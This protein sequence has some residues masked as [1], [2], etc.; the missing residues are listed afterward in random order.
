[1]PPSSAQPPA[2]ASMADGPW[3]CSFTVQRQRRHDTVHTAAG[4]SLIEQAKFAQLIHDHLR[5]VADSVERRRHWLCPFCQTPKGNEE[6]L[7]ANMQHLGERATATCDRYSCGK[8]FPLYDDLE[9]LF[10]DPGIKRR[11]QSLS[12][13]EPPQLTARRKGKLLLLQV[14]ARL[15]SANQKWQ[16]IPG[17]EDD[18]I[19]VQV[20]F[21][22][23]DGNGTGH[24]LFLQLKA[25]PSHLKTWLERGHAII[26]PD[27]HWDGFVSHGHQTLKLAGSIPIAA[28]RIW[29][30]HWPF[31]V[32]C[33]HKQWQLC[34]PDSIEIHTVYTEESPFHSIL[35]RTVTD[36]AIHWIL[37]VRRNIDPL[38]IDHGIRQLG[39]VINQGSR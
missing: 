9:R 28:D 26:N 1:M 6:V 37:L 22:D 39:C 35:N 38:R 32:L 11:A 4:L 36:Q 10:T 25:G 16:E 24:Y 3:R 8:T 7:M 30:D 21:T 15:T 20:E 19:D 14:C 12:R 5:E 17:D 2:L 31:T 13:E 33:I 23:D 29:A 18:G 34:W 27:L